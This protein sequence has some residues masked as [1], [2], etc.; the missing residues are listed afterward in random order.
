MRFSELEHSLDGIS[1]RTLTLKLKRLEE[2]GIATKSDL[3]Y[4]LTARGKQLKK[5][6]TAMESWGKK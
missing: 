4:A 6:I 3:H 5:V 2:E 1:T